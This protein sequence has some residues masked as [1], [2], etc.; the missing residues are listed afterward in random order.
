MNLFP[1]RLSGAIIA[2]PLRA[3]YTWKQLMRAHAHDSHGN[4]FV[5]YSYC[6]SVVIE[7]RKRWIDSTLIFV[8]TKHP[9]PITFLGW[10]AEFVRFYRS[11]LSPAACSYYLQALKVSELSHI[12]LSSQ[13]TQEPSKVEEGN[14][15]FDSS[16]PAGRVF[17]KFEDRNSCSRCLETLLLLWLS[18][19]FN[20][21]T[22]KSVSISSKLLFDFKSASLNNMIADSGHRRVSVVLNKTRT[23]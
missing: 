19:I 11:E 6:F 22:W 10:I 18:W 15:A 7:R 2:L 21:H 12:L 4:N 1:H 17:D 16:F 23:I 3:A 9:S 20:I 8:S 14:N 5:G 13:K